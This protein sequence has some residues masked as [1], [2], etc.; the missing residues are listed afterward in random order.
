MLHFDVF[1]P[2]KCIHSERPLASTLFHGVLLLSNDLR[3]Y[4]IFPKI[5]YADPSAVIK[6]LAK[7]APQDKHKFF[8][9]LAALESFSDAFFD[10]ELRIYTF[11][12]LSCVYERKSEGH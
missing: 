5:R 7:I 8:L 4:D 11:Q 6:I 3:S 9:P 1:I 10:W 12:G 2:S